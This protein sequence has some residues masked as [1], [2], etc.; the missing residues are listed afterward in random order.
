MKDLNPI[1]AQDGAYRTSV[2]LPLT[3]RGGRIR[4]MNAM[5]S[6]HRARHAGWKRRSIVETDR[7]GQDMLGRVTGELEIRVSTR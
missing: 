2:Q 5:R 3:P 7:R 1:I 4:A 6:P